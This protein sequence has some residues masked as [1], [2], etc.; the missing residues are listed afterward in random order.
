MVLTETGVLPGDISAID[1][2]VA[3]LVRDEE[4]RQATTLMLIPS[5]NYASLAIRQAQGSMLNNKYAE[6]YPRRRYYNGNRY[7]DSI[8]AL[9]IRRAKELFGA[10]HANVQPHAGAPANMAAYMALLKPGDTILG[11]A[12]DHGGHLTHGWPVNFSGQLYRAVQ[13]GVDRETGLIDYDQVER[14]AMAERPQLIVVGATAYPRVF[15][16]ARFRE[17]ADR[18]GALLLADMAHVAG[19]IAAGAHPHAFPH[20]DVVTFTTHKTMRGPRGAMILSKEAHARAID[21]AVFPGLQGG[22]FEHV[23]A[24]KAVMLREAATP[25]FRE[26]GHQ[27]VRNARALAQALAERG[28]RLVSGG[29]DNHLLLV[30]LTPQGITGKEAANLLEAGGLVVNKNTVPFDPRPPAE[31]SGIRLGTPAVTTRG[32]REPEMAKIAVWIDRLLRDRAEET[33]ARVRAE[34]EELALRFWP[35]SL[36]PLPAGA[37]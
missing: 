22:P 26:Y 33:A 11:M 25:E 15:D 9:C 37:A 30:D 10:E 27:I 6:G 12:L 16:F 2:E 36:G 34:V 7:V 13:Y 4:R 21:R 31:G 23:I 24:A 3:E 18:A 8:E 14:L 20:A 17:I 19:L 35:D 28:F 29:T 32:M 5:E 1:P